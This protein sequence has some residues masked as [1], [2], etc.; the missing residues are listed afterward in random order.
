MPF[1]ALK[2]PLNSLSNEVRALFALVQDGIHTVQRALWQ[3]GWDLLKIDLFSAHSRNIDDITN[4]YK[5][6]F[7]GYHLFIKQGERT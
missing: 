1:P 7:R 3:A 2:L 6:Y 5:G 4:C